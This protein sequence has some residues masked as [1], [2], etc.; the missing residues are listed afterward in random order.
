[1]MLIDH[2]TSSGRAVE[3]SGRIQPGT[4]ASR[5]SG[6]SGRKSTSSG[7]MM[8]GLSSV[9]TVVREPIFLDLPYRG[10]LPDGSSRLPITVS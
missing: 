4:E 10:H 7:R 9:W 8:L 3:M 1:M 5:Y 2:W 6:G